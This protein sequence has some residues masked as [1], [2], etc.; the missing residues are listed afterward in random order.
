MLLIFQIVYN[1]ISP[2][3]VYPS[4]WRTT[5]NAIFK[6][7]GIQKLAKYYRGISIVYPM[8]K[9][10]DIIMLNRFVAWFKPCDQQTGCHEE[11]VCL[12]NLFT[13]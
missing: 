10:F 1:S 3:Y 8:S 2:F 12:D 13:V 6:N 4:T 5:V 7:K 9:T 11:I